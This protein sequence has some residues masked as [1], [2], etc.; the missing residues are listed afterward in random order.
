[1]GEVPRP[2]LR[3]PLRRIRAQAEAPIAG[4]CLPHDQPESFGAGTLIG[5][6]GMSVASIAG[7]FHLKLF[8][9]LPIS[10]EGC[11]SGIAGSRD[12]R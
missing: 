2:S 7:R 12:C 8:E 11:M 9:K 6:R 10:N 4:F 1:M 5:H 3:S